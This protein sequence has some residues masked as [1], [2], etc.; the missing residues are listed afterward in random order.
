LSCPLE[1][2]EK[3]ELPEMFG[4]EFQY[5]PELEPPLSRPDERDGTDGTD[6]TAD[7][8]LRPE[9]LRPLSLLPE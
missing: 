2:A 6:C 5:C 9:K 7:P 3:R 8:L 1:P 4:P